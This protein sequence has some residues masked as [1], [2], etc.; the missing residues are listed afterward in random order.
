MKEQFSNPFA[1]LK[2]MN[3]LQPLN[4]FILMMISNPNYSQSSHSLWN[5]NDMII[6][7]VYSV[8]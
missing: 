8:V 6:N 2:G 4:A 7:T 1:F 5:L 3:G